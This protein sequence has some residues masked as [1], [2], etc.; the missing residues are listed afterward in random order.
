MQYLLI[1]HCEMYVCRVDVP[2][3]PAPMTLREGMFG[4]ALP[5]PTE[6]PSLEPTPS[7]RRRRRTDGVGSKGFIVLDTGTP[8]HSHDKTMITSL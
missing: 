3:L 2:A 8:Y 5:A 6:C 4:P 1:Q 7:I